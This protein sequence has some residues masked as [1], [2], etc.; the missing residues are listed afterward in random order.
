LRENRCFNEEHPAKLRHWRR[1]PS[2]KSM[3]HQTGND[4]TPFQPL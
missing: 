3:T 1:Q 4:M 2:A